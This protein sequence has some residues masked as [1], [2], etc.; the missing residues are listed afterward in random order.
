MLIRKSLFGVLLLIVMLGPGCS[1]KKYAMNKIGDTLAS[2]NSVY[3]SDEDIELVGEA[4]P[5]GLKLMESLL[6][7]SPNHRGLLVSACQGFV[8]YS[9]AYVDYEAELAEDEDLDR[10]RVLRTR[11]RK[12]Y[13]RAF[14]YG[15]RGLEISYPR[16]ESNLVADPAA[17]LAVIHNKKKKQ[18]DV[19]LL[20]WTAASLG[21]AIS[22]SSSDAASLARLPEVE[23]MLERALDLDEGWDAGAL[24]AFKIQ[25]A[26]A[27][28]GDADYNG[29]RNHYRRAL[30]LS[31]GKSAGLY[32]AYAEAVSLPR[33]NKAEFRSLLQKAL[34]VDP[35]ETPPTRL[36]NLLAHR[37]AHWLLARIDDLILDDEVGEDSGENR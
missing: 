37:R 26:A 27:K 11:A 4:L 17:A 1:L 6:A 8:L 23:A 5:F 20:Y 10:A 16:L 36:V 34:S 7:E 33:Q 22:V 32:V 28:L 31:E 3:E 35:D 15:M 30:A 24:H 19:P 25:L 13:L 9:Y 12:L 18:Q 29:M 2:G 14:R 21:L